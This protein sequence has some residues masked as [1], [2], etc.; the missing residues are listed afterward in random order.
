MIEKE[1]TLFQEITIPIHIKTIQSHPL[2]IIVWLFYYHLITNHQKN[3]LI[4]T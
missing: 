3:N 4:T 2:F 1:G